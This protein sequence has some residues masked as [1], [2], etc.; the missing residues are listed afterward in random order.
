MLF[1]LKH[2]YNIHRAA[3]MFLDVLSIFNVDQLPV[4]PKLFPCCRQ[5]NTISLGSQQQRP[6]VV[7]KPPCITFLARLM[8]GKINRLFCTPLMKKF[9]VISRSKFPETSPRGLWYSSLKLKCE[10]RRS[11]WKKIKGSPQTGQVILSKK[12]RARGQK[13]STQ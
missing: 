10:K 4:P 1:R 2:K 11:L 8:A 3:G 6:D 7:N 5:E 13:R 12:A 9:V